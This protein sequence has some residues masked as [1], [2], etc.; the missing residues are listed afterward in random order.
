MEVNERALR[1][2]KQSVLPLLG[3]LCAR[4]AVALQRFE[5]E[6]FRWT[7]DWDMKRLPSVVRSKLHHLRGERLAMALRLADAYEE[8]LSQMADLPEQVLH[9]DLNASRAY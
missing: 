5:A 6:G 1:S 7:W 3:R 2:P 9:A 4:I 8:A